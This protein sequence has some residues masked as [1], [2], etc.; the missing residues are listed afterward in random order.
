MKT[1]KKVMVSGLASGS[2]PLD[3]YLKWGE[4]YDIEKLE[5]LALAG[6]V[7]TDIKGMSYRL[8]KTEPTEIT[9]AFDYV[10]KPREDYFELI[11]SQGWEHIQSLDYAH[12]FKAPLGTAPFHSSKEVKA[13]VLA[14]VAGLNFRNFWIMVALSVV[15]LLTLNGLPEGTPT[16]VHLLGNVL[17]L[18]GGISALFFIISAIGFY[19]RKEATLKK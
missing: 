1:T 11:Q 9:Y 16:W 14:T 3:K 17:I 10:M 15:L 18:L 13:E 8:I 2:G 19:Q 4:V 7:V 12:M 5:K 6:W